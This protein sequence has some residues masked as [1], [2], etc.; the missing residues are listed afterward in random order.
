MTLNRIFFISIVLLISQITLM[1]T[2]SNAEE[3]NENNTAEINITVP[4][5]NTES[6]EN[7]SL[8]SLTQEDIEAP[9]TQFGLSE[10]IF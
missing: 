8:T 4:S 1:V 6:A 10:S 3:G 2:L 7:L 5:T 9:P